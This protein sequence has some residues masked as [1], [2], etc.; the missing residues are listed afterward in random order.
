MSYLS[1]PSLT[2]ESVSRARQGNVS[3]FNSS[4]DRFRRR[5][6]LS[7]IQLI[8]HPTP[9]PATGP[10][11]DMLRRLPEAHAILLPFLDSPT[12]PI[13]HAGAS[14]LISFLRQ[15][16]SPP[17]AVM[18]YI[19]ADGVDPEPTEPFVW[20]NSDAELC[21]GR[22]AQYIDILYAEIGGAAPPLDGLTQNQA[23]ALIQDLCVRASRVRNKVSTRV[24]AE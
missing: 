17:P 3:K 22:Q 6:R 14:R 10:Q 12:Q 11:I 18:N 8:P 15:N 23:S 24:R 16:P 20:P 7:S 2:H 19:L 13:N 9:N 21:T 5:R 1:N 4:K